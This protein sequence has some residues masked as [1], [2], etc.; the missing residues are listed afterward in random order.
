MFEEFVTQSNSQLSER[1]KAIDSLLQES[2]SKNNEYREKQ[3]T[4]LNQLMETVVSGL[5]TAVVNR[6]SNHGV[7]VCR[8]IAPYNQSLVRILLMD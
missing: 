6:D 5:D 2:N 7:C 1:N 8:L 4:C 3:R